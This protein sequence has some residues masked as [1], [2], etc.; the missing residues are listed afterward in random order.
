MELDILRFLCNNGKLASAARN[1]ILELRVMGRRIM[2]RRSGVH[3]MQE[4]EWEQLCQIRDGCS[5]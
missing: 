3:A 5:F 2:G 1:F 4:G